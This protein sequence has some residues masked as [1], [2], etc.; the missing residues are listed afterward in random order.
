MS[1]K[2]SS[3]YSQTRKLKRMS[4]GSLSAVYSMDCPEAS[5]PPSLQ[6]SDDCMFHYSECH[7]HCNRDQKCELECYGD[8]DDCMRL[9]PCYDECPQGCDGCD[10]EYCV[11]GDFE[12]EPN[13]IQCKHDAED[14]YHRCAFDCPID[15]LSCF[16]DCS[17]EYHIAFEKCPCQ[18]EILCFFSSITKLR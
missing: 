5:V 11:C 13:F 6:C 4:L 10:S 8:L 15:E 1:S 3:V 7:F 17:R 12:S 9:C 16:S 2:F 14:N 18:V